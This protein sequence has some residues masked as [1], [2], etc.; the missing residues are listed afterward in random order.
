[1]EGIVDTDVDN[2]VNAFIRMGVLVDDADLDK[3]KAKVKSNFESG[4]I[5]VKAKNKKGKLKPKENKIQKE[6]VLEGT[7][8]ST[9]SSNTTTTQSIQE[10]TSSTIDDNTI[11]P[12]TTI[13]QINSTNTQQ[14]SLQSSSLSSNKVDDDAE[15]MS[16]FTLPAEYAFVA[17]AISQMDGVGKSLDKDFDFI[18]ASAPYIV[19]IKGG[20][21]YVKDEIMK[22]LI[23]PFMKIQVEVQKMIGDNFG[24]FGSGR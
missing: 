1:M 7:I 11:T 14:P 18:S 16:Y 22:K 24:F 21:R 2:C 15:I 12:T 13:Q 8:H 9:D 4:L 17:R 3:V 10:S 5:K 23:Q 19:E 6:N 20:E